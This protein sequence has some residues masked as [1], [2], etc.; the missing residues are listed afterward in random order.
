MS[1]IIINTKDLESN[2]DLITID[3]YVAKRI[4]RRKNLAKRNTIKYPLFAV[5]FTQEEFPDYSRA[6]YE[7]DI[8]GKK[9]PRYKKGKST[10]V[11]YG[12]YHEMKRLLLEYKN[13]LMFDNV[14]DLELLLRIQRLRNSITKRYRILYQLKRECIEWSF[15]ATYSYELIVELTKIKFST[16]NELEDRINSL[17]KYSNIK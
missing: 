10:L 6:L 9:K 11:R 15:P 5:Q 1:K 13:K 4:R 14:N 2:H 16:F 3:Q 8:K 17:T 12:R 7:K